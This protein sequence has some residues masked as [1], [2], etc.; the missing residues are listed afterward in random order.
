MSTAKTAQVTRYCCDWKTNVAVGNPHRAHWGLFL[1]VVDSTSWPTHDWPVARRHHI[2]T[3]AERNE[4]LA[5]FGYQPAP[6]A[7]WEWA[8]DETPTYHGH[9]SEPFVFASIRIVPIEQP[10]SAT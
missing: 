2:P 9:P 6:D 10:G 4:A 1:V 5:Q 3:R 8:E 7:E